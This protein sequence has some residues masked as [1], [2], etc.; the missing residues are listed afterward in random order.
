MYFC[1]GLEKLVEYQFSDTGRME[2]EAGLQF[3]KME[4]VLFGLS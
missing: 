2:K 4:K 1:L 3:R